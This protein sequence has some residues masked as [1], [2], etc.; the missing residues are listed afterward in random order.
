MLILLPS[1][2]AKSSVGRGHA[3]DPAR[4]SFPAL[5]PTRAAVLAALIEVSGLPDATHRLGVRE[6]LGEL[7]HRNVSLRE[8]PTA[9]AA[10]VYSGVVYD[11]IG[12]ANLDPPSQR[13]ARAWIVVV[14]ALWGA[15]RLGDRIPSY[16]LNM[17]GRLP[18]LGHLPQVWQA[19]LAEVL[20]AAAGRGVVVDFRAAE[21]ATAW[22]PT[23][24]LAE[25]TV[26]VKVVRDDERSR[27]AGSYNAK[28]T[29][30]R[31]VRRIVI[32]AIDAYRPEALAELLAQHFEVD[33]RHPR[34]PGHP[35]SLHVVESPS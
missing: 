6:N 3:L 13:R 35:W 17:C 8:A 26:V 24:A 16:R 15:V 31:I 9:S 18:G 10:T 29:Q 19:P 33:L 34:R 7:V 5:A 27:G 14:S 21:Y 11:A 25:R 4:L 30:G 22:R 28:H 23:G 32:D 12:V 20:P 2:E 1:S